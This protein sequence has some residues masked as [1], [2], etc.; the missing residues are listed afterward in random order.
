MPSSQSPIPYDDHQQRDGDA[1]VEADDAGVRQALLK[2]SM[3][4]CDEQT[5]VDSTAEDG[6]KNREDQEILYNMMSRSDDA[7]MY[8]SLTLNRKFRRNNDQ[9][10]RVRSDFSKLSTNKQ[11]NPA[12]PALKQSRK[13]CQKGRVRFSA[14]TKNHDGL[15]EVS[16]AYDALVWRYCTKM[17][18]K[19]ARDVCQHVGW[20]LHVLTGIQRLTEELYSRLTEARDVE[21][22]LRELWDSDP[23]APSAPPMAENQERSSAITF[24]ERWDPSEDCRCTRSD[25]DNRKYNQCAQNEQTDLPQR[26]DSD[27]SSSSACSSDPQAD[28]ANESE[29]SDSA[30]CPMPPKPA[31][32]TIRAPTCTFAQLAESSACGP[33]PCAETPTAPVESEDEQQNEEKQRSSTSEECRRILRT[34]STKPGMVPVLRTGGG[35]AAMLKSDHIP[36]VEKLL[37]LIEEATELLQDC[38]QTKYTQ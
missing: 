32:L 22:R 35:T 12:K 2:L 19:D 33:R 26:S 34:C 6:I 9:Q 4:H 10:K 11:R 3:L 5:N 20:K 1:S 17:D 23:S 37:E 28:S 25:N 38:N 36:F 14:A 7:K 27:S 8:P 16:W 24:M 31:G 18:I 29:C 15:D 13:R 21:N 30:D